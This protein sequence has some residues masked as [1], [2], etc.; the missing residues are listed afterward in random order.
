M[1]S[2]AKLLVTDRLAE[3]SLSVDTERLELLRTY[4]HRVSSVLHAYPTNGV[5][6]KAYSD[7]IFRE[8]FMTFKEVYL[9]LLWNRPLFRVTVQRPLFSVFIDVL[10]P[11]TQA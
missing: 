3:G 10:L 6:M 7:I 1:E 2:Q 8:R 11:G 4:G 9:Q 5:V